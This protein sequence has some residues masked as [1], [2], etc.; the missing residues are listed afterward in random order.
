MMD[1]TAILPFIMSNY[2]IVNKTPLN[3]MVLAYKAAV[4]LLQVCHDHRN[5]GICFTWPLATPRAR[6]GP[7]H[8][9]SSVA[10]GYNTVPTTQM[11][12]D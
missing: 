4:G 10:A 12:S 6:Q 2:N 7:R 8:P 11:H 9:V 1:D 3:L 5:Q